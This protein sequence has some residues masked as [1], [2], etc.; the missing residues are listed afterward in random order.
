MVMLCVHACMC[1]MCACMYVWCVCM[2]VCCGMCMCVWCSSN[3]G[4]K[5][6]KDSELQDGVSFLPTQAYLWDNNEVVK[7]WLEEQM[8]DNNQST[9]IQNT[10]CVKKHR[11][12]REVN[13]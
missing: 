4:R 10:A 13:T 12:L 2:H 11:V 9:L 7:T 6:P 1:G 8:K 5:T 3:V